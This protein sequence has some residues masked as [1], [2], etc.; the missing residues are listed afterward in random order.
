MSLLPAPRDDRIGGDAVDLRAENERLRARVLELER[1]LSAAGIS[2]GGTGSGTSSSAAPAADHRTAP[3]L[4]LARVSPLPISN[5]HVGSAEVSSDV[6][7]AQTGAGSEPPQRG[8]AAETDISSANDEQFRFGH[9]SAAPSLDAAAIRR[10]SR[11]MILPCV[12]AVAQV[13][14][15]MNLMCSDC[16]H[17]LWAPIDESRKPAIHFCK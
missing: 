4:P 5:T 6:S 17:L 1:T 12:G 8:I 16:C 15:L 2:V 13:T 10:Y 7:F 9:I 3:C 11:Q 14:I